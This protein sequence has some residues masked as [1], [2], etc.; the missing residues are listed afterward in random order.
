[1]PAVIDRIFE[2]FTTAG[3]A[4]YFGEDVTELEHALQAA[5]LAEQAG[6]DDA[7]VSAALLHDLG[8][9][10]HGLPEDIAARGIDG[11]HEDAGAAWLG[12]HFGPAVVDPVR[13]HV[14]AKRYLCATEPG[15][16][17]A[18]SPSSRLSL[19][20]Q[21]GPFNPAEV[22]AFEAEPWHRSAVA[23]RRWDDAAK[24][25]GLAVPGL[26]HYRPRLEAVLAQRGA[27]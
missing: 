9:L 16:L 7:L 4:A 5:H 15:Y 13:L 27:E 8:H 24:V 20:L 22:R 23:V 19:K 12:R 14:A 3:Q 21:G 6:A 11:R 2:V 10:L 26:G 18:L 17:D 1:M 25:P